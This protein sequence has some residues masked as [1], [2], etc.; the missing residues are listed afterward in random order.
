VI[1]RGD[2]QGERFDTLGEGGVVD[3]QMVSEL[4]HRVREKT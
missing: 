2:A 1:E 3:T 4:I